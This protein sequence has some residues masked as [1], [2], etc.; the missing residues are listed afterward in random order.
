MGSIELSNY[1]PKEHKRISN[2]SVIGVGGGGSNAVDYMYQQGSRDVE[3]IICNTDLQ[4]LNMKSVPL[5]I[6]IGDGL[7]AGADPSRAKEY[8][9]RDSERIRAAF[10]EQDTKM[11]FITAGMGGGTGTGA[12]PVIARIAREMGILA[13][14]IVTMPLKA[15]GRPR[16]ERAKAGL[17]ELKENLDAILIIDNTMVLRIYNNLKWNEAFA[18]ADE[19]LA[20]GAQSLAEILLKDDYH[21]NVDFNDV[22]KTMSNAGFFLM[23]TAVVK[24]DNENLVDELISSTLQSPLFMQND[25]VGAQNILIS[26]TNGVDGLSAAAFEEIIERIQNMTDDTAEVIAAIGEDD[27]LAPDEVKLTIVAAGFDSRKAL[28]AFNIDVSKMEERV[29]ISSGVKTFNPTIRM[30]DDALTFFESEPAYKRNGRE[31]FQ[32]IEPHKKRMVKIEEI[33]NL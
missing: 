24:S 32:K 16:M 23:G 31:V 19:I 3:F 29:F 1:I 10:I 30:D 6:M 28:Q 11:V 13:V 20:I 17:L 26:L 21:W 2:I 8:A 9:D 33:D 22:F 7:G 5:K 27:K 4:A 25:I 12:A 15:E 14:G 18:K